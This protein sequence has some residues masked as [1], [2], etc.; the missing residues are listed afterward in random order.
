[1][2]AVNN[3]FNNIKMEI[4]DEKICLLTLDNSK[5][6]NILDFETLEEFK[7][8]I[9][10]INSDNNIE[11]AIITG[12]GDKLFSAGAD[13]KEMIKMNLDQN[14][15]YCELAISVVMSIFRSEKIFISAINGFAI[16]GGL[17]LI[18]SCDIR[19]ASANAKFKSPEVK[20]GI[21]CG[22]SGTQ[23]LP[24]IV[25]MSNAKDMLLTGKV[26]DSKR[27]LEIGLVHYIFDIDKL[28][29][30]VISIAKEIVNC[31]SKAVSNTKYLINKSM[32]LPLTEGLKLET[33]YFTKL[34]NSDEGKRSLDSFINKKN[35]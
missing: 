6:L 28:I 19:V 33:E 32:E 29:D 25:G 4:I 16:G 3:L 26:V 30:N 15:D 17:E 2:K 20:L 1:M 5:G 8:A 21:I 27:A 10:Q 35:K 12:A 18:L 24:R 23:M 11:V 31:N 14:K 9:Y 13:I 22:F 34:V 7:S